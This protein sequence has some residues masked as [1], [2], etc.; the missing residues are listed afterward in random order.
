MNVAREYADEIRENRPIY[1]QGLKFTPLAVRHFALYQNARM[2]MELMQ[3]SL[4]IRLARMG[5]I[6]CLEEMDKEAVENGLKP[7]L[8]ASFLGLLDAALGLGALNNP[9][10][11]QETRDREGK[12]QGLLIQQEQNSPVILTKPMLDDVRKILAAQNGY[13]IPDE[14]WNPEL[15]KA[16]QYLQDQKSE[17]GG[18]LEDAVYALA[19][20]AGRDPEE[21]WN[22]PIRKYRGMQSAKHRQ[23]MFMIC[24]ALELSGQV[25]FKRGNPYATWI[26]PQESALPAGFTSLK[27]LEDGAK[28]LLSAPNE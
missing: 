12:L 21:I 27:E 20:A 23:M 15:V 25:K 8:Y 3:A 22:W 6:S 9:R 11:L 2:A 24:T 14:S 10:R 1:Y 26:T 16:A 18:S 4:P 5:W 13:E 19:I 28:G 7:S 17:S